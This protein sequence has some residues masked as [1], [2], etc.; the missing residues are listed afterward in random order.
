MTF[1]GER[2]R[3]GN[4]LGM[5]VIGVEKIT[6]FKLSLFDVLRLKSCGRNMLLGEHASFLERR[7]M[8]DSARPTFIGNMIVHNRGVVNDCL[9]HVGIVDDR[10]V[11]IDDRRVVN[12]VVIVPFA[13]YEADAHVPKA[14]VHAAVIADVPSPI[15]RM[16]DIQVV[17]PSP[18]GRCPECPLKRRWNPGPGNPIVL[19]RIVVILPKP[20]NPDEVRFGAGRLNIN[21]QWRRSEANADEHAGMCRGGE[22][23]RS[24]CD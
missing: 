15:A 10:S 8:L 3:Q 19:L 1:N 7:L 21:G 23:Q 5:P 4:S 17:I 14:V 20:W 9:V 12:E 11:H 22:C 6:S 2:T 24:K 16:K 13:T 18:V